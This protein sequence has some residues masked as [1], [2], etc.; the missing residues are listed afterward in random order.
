MWDKRVVRGNTY[1]S[2]VTKKGEDPLKE[3]SKATSK[4]PKPILK[5]VPSFL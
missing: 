4:Q 2:M 5:T 1:A 3:H